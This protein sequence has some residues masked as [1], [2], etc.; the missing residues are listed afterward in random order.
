MPQDLGL[1][2]R[3]QPGRADGLAEEVNS[4]GGFAQVLQTIRAL[5]RDVLGHVNSFAGRESSEQE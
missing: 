3:T 5:A 1:Q 2:L 4:E